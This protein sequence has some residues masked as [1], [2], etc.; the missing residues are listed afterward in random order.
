MLTC[1]KNRFSLP[2]NV[3]Y[4]NAAYFT[5]LLDVVELAGYRGVTK[6]TMPFEVTSSDFFDPVEPLRR[7]FASL[8]H[9]DEPGR[10]AIV[11]SVSYGIANAAKNVR[12]ERGQKIVLIEEQFPSNYYSWQRTADEKGLRLQI[13]G[14]PK[15]TDGRAAQWNE[16]LLAAITSDTAV[17]TLPHVHWADGTKFDLER[18]GKKCREVGAQFIVDGT[19]SVGALPFDVSV[20]QPDALI[21]SGYKWLLGPYSIGLA[22]YGEAFDAGTPIE[23]SWMNRAHSDDFQGLVQYQSEYRPFAARYNVGEFSNFILIPMMS[24]ALETILDWRVENIQEYCGSLSAPFLEAFVEMGCRLES[25]EYRGQHLIGI[26]TGDNFDLEDLK[27]A[28]A[29]NR[30]YVSFRGEVVRISPHLY[31]DSGDFEKLIECFKQNRKT[32]LF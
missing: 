11:P 16:N 19:Q 28:L 24:A 20:I 9:A 29:K 17:V 22:Y 6:K 5:P 3:T 4:F 7:M 10:V 21:C 2:S 31:N 15:E 18:V 27:H 30:I 14:A 1:Q 12:A 25:P 13:V 26:R 23:E 32:K 8:I